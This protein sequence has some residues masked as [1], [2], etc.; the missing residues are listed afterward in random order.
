MLKTL[1]LANNGES[2]VRADQQQRVR[3]YIDLR[4]GARPACA[5]PS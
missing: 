4:S 5:L 3:D 2:G 1:G